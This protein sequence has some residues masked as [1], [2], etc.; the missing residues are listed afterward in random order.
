MIF[1][2]SSNSKEPNKEPKTTTNRK[3]KS[4]VYSLDKPNMTPAQYGRYKGSTVF[5]YSG[6]SK[7]KEYSTDDSILLYILIIRITQQFRYVRCFSSNIRKFQSF[8]S[9][10]N[11]C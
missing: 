3:G 6:C 4:L 11:Y 8:F 10:A 9:D 1:G 2:V 7:G 5:D